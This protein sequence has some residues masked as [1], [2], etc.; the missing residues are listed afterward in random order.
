M[1]RLAR[2]SLNA[3]QNGLPRA[4][5]F[6]TPPPQTRPPDRGLLPIFT[7]NRSKINKKMQKMRINRL[8]HAVLL[9]VE[10]FKNYAVSGTRILLAKCGDDHAMH[11]T[12]YLLGTDAGSIVIEVITI[13]DLL[14][15]CAATGGSARK[16]TRP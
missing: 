12:F 16:N 15:V 14:G 9:R 2:I 8:R 11:T 10:R 5:E 1:G 3:Q 7:L 6:C 4:C 13:A